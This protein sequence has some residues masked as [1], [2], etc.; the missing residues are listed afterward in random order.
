M[1][2]KNKGCSLVL[3]A[4]AVMV[5][6]AVLTFHPAQA[7]A[8]DLSWLPAQVQV[9]AAMKT[10]PVVNAAAARLDAAAATQSA[11]EAGSHEFELSSGLQR[12]NVTNEAH[13]YNEWEIQLSRAVRLPNK[14]RIDRD[15]GS[16]TR[17]VADMRLEDAELQMARRLLEVWAGWL[18]SFIVAD[19]MQAQEKLLIRE[20]EAMAR[21]VAL[22]DA[23]QRDSDVLQAERAMLAA[24]VSAARDAERAARQTM[25]I[26][27]PGIE[28]PARP[29]TLPDPDP[30][31]GGVQEWLARIV[32]QSVEIGIAD[33]E[34]AR[35]AKVAERGRANRTPDPTVG[36]RM[37]SERGGTERVIGVVLTVPFG[38][39]YRSAMAATESA[40]AAAAEAE[41]LGVRR[42]VE[43]SAWVAA[44]A[45]ESKRTQWQSFAQALA[46]QTTAS[47]RTRRA[48]ELGEAPLAEYLLTLR[49]LRQTRLGEAQARIDALQASALVRIDAHALWHS[50]EAHADAP[51]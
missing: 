37:M 43:Q 40:N 21:R 31:P 2:S 26:E 27:F 9:E 19:E 10:Q 20:Q 44:Q 48:W 45:A 17:R 13:R 30:L 46:A 23:A 47:N 36:V 12:R 16:R 3:P 24:Q 49:N 29:S 28:I 22:G 14:A 39:D 51:Q 42:A 32:R 25:V 33:G 5:A 34:A 8:D 38:T 15:I 35:L 4:G 41:A 6:I 7:R 18:R 1:T 50:K 11:L